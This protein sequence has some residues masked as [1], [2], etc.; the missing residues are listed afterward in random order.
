MPR[1]N[2][3]NIGIIPEELR[4]KVYEQMAEV[5]GDDGVV[6]DEELTLV[7]AMAAV[8][9]CPVPDAMLEA[10]GIAVT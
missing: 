3:Y 6:S 9:D 5:A 4:P 2:A 1:R 10:H 7:K 8:M